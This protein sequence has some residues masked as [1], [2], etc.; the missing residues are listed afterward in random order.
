VTGEL[1]LLNRQTKKP[2]GKIL[3]VGGGPTT[4]L[5]IIRSFGRKRFDVHVANDST[6]DLALYSR[7]ITKAHT[8]S[9]SSVAVQRKSDIIRIMK[10]EKF[11]LVIPVGDQNVIPFNLFR[12]EYESAGRIYLLN[13]NAFQLTN[14]KILTCQLARSLGIPVPHSE[15][16]SDASDSSTVLSKFA[17]PVMLKP[18]SSYTLANLDEKKQ[19]K[20]IDTTEQG[21]QS[22]RGMLLYG[23]VI[24]Q[25]YFEGIGI[26]LELLAHKG[27]ILTSFQHIRIHEEGKSI[28]STYRQSQPVH[29]MFLSAAKKMMKALNYTGVAMFEFRSNPDKKTWVLIE[30]NGRFWGSLPLPLACGVDFPYYLYQMLVEE[31][32]KFPQTY[33]TGLYCRNT[34][35]DLQW[36]GNIIFHK[37]ATDHKKGYSIIRYV[38]EWGNILLLQEKND[39]FV[40]DDPY[41]GIMELYRLFRKS[42]SM[43][44]SKVQKKS[45]RFHYSQKEHSKDLQTALK[46]THSILFVCYGNICRS[47]FAGAYLR[48]IVL[49]GI[50]IRSCGYYPVADRACPV[51]AVFAAKKYGVDLSGYRSK[52]IN[53]EI[54]QESNI[55]FV[56]DEKNL[57]EITRRY[58]QIVDK[59]WYLSELTQKAPITIPDPYGKD[60]A[61]YE[62]VYGDIADNIKVV[63]SL[64]T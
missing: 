37:D 29:E 7:Y 1:Q 11:D 26:G 46:N 59:V 17:L 12:S 3:V 63:A 42:C 2:R 56:F 15:I 23:Q 18:A 51:E 43:V 60:L 40:L 10:E 35:A 36:M 41:P 64:L 28:G 55:I 16:I 58:P 14:N 24:V 38:F 62:E 21:E 13:S 61:I 52:V 32:R 8:I 53:D 30:I 9:P 5:S 44:L 33:R 48:K 4:F 27:E 20:R 39:V 57:Q 45:A 49:S 50:Q 6:T 22:L 31:R 47:P 34:S 19:V 54:I 25:E